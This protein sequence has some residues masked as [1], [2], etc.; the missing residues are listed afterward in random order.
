M[1]AFTRSQATQA[2]NLCRCRLMNAH[3]CPMVNSTAHVGSPVRRATRNIYPRPCC[4]AHALYRSPRGFGQPS[5]CRGG[6]KPDRREVK[7]M[8]ICAGEL[9]LSEGI[10][11]SRH[12]QCDLLLRSG[13]VRNSSFGFYAAD[14]SRA[15]QSLRSQ[16]FRR[17]LKPG[18]LPKCTELSVHESFCMRPQPE[19]LYEWFHSR[20]H[21]KVVMLVD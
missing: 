6:E 14:S 1:K 20:C 7:E 2:I 10:V 8:S 9:A 13:H 3:V 19:M 17:R 16:K 11:Q 12:R 21:P 4:E 15:P 18:S 5:K